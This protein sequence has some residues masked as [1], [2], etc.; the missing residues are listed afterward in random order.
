[1][2]YFIGLGLS[3]EKDITVRHVAVPGRCPKLRIAESLP[4]EHCMLTPPTPI[5]R[6]GLEIVKACQRIYLEAYTSVLLVPKERLVRMLATYKHCKADA[7]LQDDHDRSRM[8]V[9]SNKHE[10]Y[11]GRNAASMAMAMTHSSSTCR[12]SSG[13]LRNGSY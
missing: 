6:R 9:I 11:S 13:L 1:M 7:A 10:R 12:P 8:S 5:G 4:T 2:L 3:D